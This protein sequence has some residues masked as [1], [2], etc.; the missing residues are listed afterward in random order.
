MGVVSAS[1]T[2][3]TVEGY[4]N[5]ERYINE[6]T[7]FGKFTYCPGQYAT[8]TSNDSNNDYVLMGSLT[9]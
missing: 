6:I 2:S 7:P 1:Y 5:V 4:W 3:F 8:V 9:G